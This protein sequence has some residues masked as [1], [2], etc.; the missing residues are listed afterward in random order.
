MPICVYYVC[1]LLS[2]IICL[3]VYILKLYLA[4]SNLLIFLRHFS[5]LANVSI[6]AEKSHLTCSSSPFLPSLSPFSK[7]E[8][9]LLLFVLSY[10]L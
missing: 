9:M 2:K 5:T 8:Y 4:L 6:A 3:L 1:I 7:K 10:S